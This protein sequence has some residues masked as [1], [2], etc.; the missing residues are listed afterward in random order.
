MMQLA[1]D[2]EIILNVYCK[3]IRSI[4]EYG[5]PVFH[6]G[7]TQSQSN[8]IEAIQRLVFGLLGR[9]LCLK[10]S[11]S[12]LCILFFKE[13]LKDHRYE[14][15]ITYVRRTLANPTYSGMFSPHSHPHNTRG[16]GKYFSELQCRTERYF[17]SPKAVLMRLANELL[18]EQST[19][20]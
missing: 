19:D 20:K 13:K 12:E 10:L 3:E 6:L 18:R 1:L 14:A 8:K 5:A 4:T 2:F 16:R 17:K 9:Y 15:C 11:Y 7:L